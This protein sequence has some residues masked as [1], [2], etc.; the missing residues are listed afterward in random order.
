MPRPKSLPSL[1]KQVASATGADASLDRA[2]AATLHDDPEAEGPHDY[3]ASV[4]ACLRLIARVAPHWHW[5][6]GH[7]PDGILPYA[8]LSKEGDDAPLVEASAPTVPLALLS[9]L[10]QALVSEAR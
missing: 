9:A 8:A 7:G 4:D 3:S 10:L 5:H 1:A 2:L 6:V